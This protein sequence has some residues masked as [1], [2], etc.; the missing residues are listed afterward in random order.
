MNGSLLNQ[1][2]FCCLYKDVDVMAAAQT[3]LDAQRQA[4]ADVLAKKEKEGKEGKV[5]VGKNEET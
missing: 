1:F 2:K 5:P 4:E 3:A